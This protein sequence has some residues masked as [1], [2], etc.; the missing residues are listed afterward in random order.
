ME[1]A[2]TYGDI[3]TA[4]FLIEM[5]VEERPLALFNRNIL[6]YLSLSDFLNIEKHQYKQKM[7]DL[8]AGKLAPG[9]T[10]IGKLC[11]LAIL[12]LEHPN[13][14][15][16]EGL[17]AIDSDIEIQ[18]API[19]AWLAMND[20]AELLDT[21][22]I[23][24]SI[25]TKY[26]QTITAALE[27]AILFDAAHSL[28]RLLLTAS[29]VDILDTMSFAIASHKPEL[30]KLIFTT[31]S[32]E[33]GLTWQQLIKDQDL[34]SIE[35]VHNPIHWAM[36]YDELDSLAFLLEN[37]VDVNAPVS[38]HFKLGRSIP[39]IHYAARSQNIKLCELLVQYNARIDITDTGGRIPLDYIKNSLLKEKLQQMAAEKAALPHLRKYARIIA[40]EERNP[41]SFFGQ[42][43]REINQYIAAMTCNT[44]PIEKAEEIVNRNYDRP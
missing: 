26:P 23:L 6:S 43:P 42:L 2:K 39:P 24:S 9:R 22:E 28:Q 29:S 11:E 18:F 7:L 38:R 20:R 25:A 3:P 34:S 13:N 30:L 41:A 1:L 5:G 4:K 14:R 44:L 8:F 35:F 10:P 36:F 33:R 27:V 40:Q 31:I 37:G 15:L 32:V 17:K 12:F 19:F 16:Y 21:N